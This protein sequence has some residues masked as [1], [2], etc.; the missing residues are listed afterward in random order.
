MSRVFFISDLH[1]GH[2]SLI[3]SLRNMEPEESD[4]LIIRNWNKTVHKK[5]TV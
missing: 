1:F 4:D 2:K 3:R 5:D